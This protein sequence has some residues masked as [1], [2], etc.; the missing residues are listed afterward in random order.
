[1]TGEGTLALIGGAGAMGSALVRGWI[2]GGAVRADRI[3][4]T[5]RDPDRLL[6]RASA[7][8]VRAIP[9]NRAA[10]ASASVVVLCVKPG[11]WRDVATELHGRLPAAAVLI[12]IVAGVPIAALQDAFGH[13][14]IVRCMPNLPCGIS[15]G[16]VPWAASAALA[17]P[18]ARTAGSGMSAMNEVGRLLGA[19]GLAIQVGDECELDFAT[20]VSSAGPAMVFL[21]M[22][23][24]V[25]AAVHAGLSRR[26]AQRMVA[27]TVRGSAQ[28]A[29]DA[30]ESLHALRAQ[31][32]SPGGV[33]AECLAALERHGFRS[34]LDGAVA[35]G[36]RRTLAMAGPQAPPS[37]FPTSSLEIA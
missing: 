36:L 31:V 27:A 24:L 35:A 7:L 21:F 1:M 26:H 19:L 8:G 20:P 17:T 37:A 34:A 5:A 12:S 3:A 13:P 11:Q 15:Q 18:A 30:G 25:D 29:Q 23:A 33:T 2:R 9:A 10:A 22:E 16:V 4:I 14:A 28:L 32:T 6:A